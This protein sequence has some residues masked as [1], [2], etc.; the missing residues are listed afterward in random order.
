[1]DSHWGRI[2]LILTQLDRQEPVQFIQIEGINLGDTTLPASQKEG[3]G[4]PPAPLSEVL[5]FTV[6]P[7]GASR[8][9][10]GDV[11]TH[12]WWQTAAGGRGLPGTRGTLVTGEVLYVTA[13]QARLS[14]GSCRASDPL[15]ATRVD[16]WS[17]CFCPG[18]GVLLMRV[19][20]LRCRVLGF[21]SGMP[22]LTRRKPQHAE[23]CCH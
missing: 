14:L 5:S 11:P 1:M 8:C 18:L 12:H 19:C 4:E 9:A 2:I 21:G 3:W 10:P 20:H 6:R 16:P 23:L 15:A 17:L 7:A 13:L 22:A